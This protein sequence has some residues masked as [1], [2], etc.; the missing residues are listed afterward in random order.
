MSVLSFT[1]LCGIANIDTGIN[2]DSATQQDAT[3]MRVLNERNRLERRRIMVKIIYLWMIPPEKFS[4]AY[5][6]LKKTSGSDRSSNHSKNPA[7]REIFI[8]GISSGKK[9]HSFADG[10]LMHLQ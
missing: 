3:W 7:L 10:S 6:Y 9:F 4:L 5:F 1:H 8:C 2:T